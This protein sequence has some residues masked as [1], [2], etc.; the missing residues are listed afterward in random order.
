MK[1]SH[2]PAIDSRNREQNGARRTH[3]DRRRRQSPCLAWHVRDCTTAAACT[4][5]AEVLDG[6]LVSLDSHQLVF[7][8]LMGLAETLRYV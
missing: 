4:N 8:R 7:G 5:V 6:P 1:L 2:T 3:D